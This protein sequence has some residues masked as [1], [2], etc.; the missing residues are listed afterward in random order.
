VLVD[1]SPND[2]VRVPDCGVSRGRG[3]EIAL[4]FAR[5]DLRRDQ[6]TGRQCR[7]SHTDYSEASFLT[8]M[9]GCGPCVA[10]ESGW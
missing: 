3:A 6:T 5:L 9:L 7:R 10:R 4:A 1:P 8:V 2:S